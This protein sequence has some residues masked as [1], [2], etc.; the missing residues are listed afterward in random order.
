MG[1][2]I[3][4]ARLHAFIINSEVDFCDVLAKAIL[5]LPILF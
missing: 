3:M 4:I 2:P 5:S 1:A